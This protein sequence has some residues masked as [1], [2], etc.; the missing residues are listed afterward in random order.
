MGVIKKAKFVVCCDS[1][2]SHIAFSFNKSCVIIYSGINNK[3]HWTVENK[4]NFVL[5]N[6]KTCIPCHS[7]V[8]C[9]NMNCISTVSNKA[10]F[11]KI[12]QTL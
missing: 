7:R 5:Q 3:R 12:M 4:K 2:A 6:K 11:D 1:I 10:V 9:K 8:N